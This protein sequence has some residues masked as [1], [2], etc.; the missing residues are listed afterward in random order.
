MVKAARCLKW[1]SFQSRKQKV[2]NMD[3][4]G[5]LDIILDHRGKNVLDVQLDTVR[6]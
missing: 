5:S 4:Y 1:V 3:H 2:G 6:S